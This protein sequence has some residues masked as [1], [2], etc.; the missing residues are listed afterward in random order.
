[1]ADFMTVFQPLDR[2]GPGT[3]EDS[4]RAL[5]L[6]P[7]TPTRILDI[8]CGKGLSA[9]LLAQHTHASVTAVD[10]EPSALAQFESKIVELGLQDR[11]STRCASMTELPFEPESFDLI[12]AEGSAYIMGFENALNQWRP[13][14]RKNG[15]LVLSE[16]VWL[17]DNPSAN[18][19][20]FWQHEYPDMQNIATRIEQIKN[21]GYELIGHFTLSHQAW[22]NYYL[23][24][25][26]RIAQLRDALPNSRALEELSR[27][28]ELYKEHLGEF[29][30]EM[31]VLKINGG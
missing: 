2:W 1:M 24:L 18:A 19:A 22:L 16:L 7:D 12:W 3:E 28:V 10:N 17:S 27:E 20:E 9:T 8:G 6:L 14:L 4:L 26:A 23:P 21:A 13:L 31:F 11:M 5:A 29:G 25:K 30:Y 15:A